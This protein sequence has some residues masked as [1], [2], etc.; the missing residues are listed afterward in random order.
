MRQADIAQQIVVELGQI[1]AIGRPPT[2]R[3]ETF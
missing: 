1:A 3:R 2:P